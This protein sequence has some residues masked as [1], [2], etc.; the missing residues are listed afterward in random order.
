MNSDV[1][2]CFS[3]VHDSEHKNCAD[4]KIENLFLLSM[5]RLFIKTVV[6]CQVPIRRVGSRRDYGDWRRKKRAIFPRN[7]WLL[8]VA[9]EHFN[10]SCSRMK[11]TNRGR[12]G[13]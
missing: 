11:Q 10:K 5:G 6:E 8:I 13:E 1:P 2:V 9:L 7:L 12:L 4:S 3:K